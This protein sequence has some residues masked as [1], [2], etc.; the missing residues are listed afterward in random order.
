M[1][2]AKGKRLYFKICVSEKHILYSKYTS[3]Q[4]KLRHV[5]YFQMHFVSDF[6]D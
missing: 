2:I 1:P 5:N 4:K 3:K 6:R